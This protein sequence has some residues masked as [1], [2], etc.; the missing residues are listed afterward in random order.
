MT[1]LLEKTLSSPDW[2]LAVPSRGGDPRREAGMVSPPPS[3]PRRNRKEALEA[4]DPYATLPQLGA[5]PASGDPGVR[6]RPAH[7]LPGAGAN[8]VLETVVIQVLPEVD[9]L[10]AL[11][12]HERA[13]LPGEGPYGRV[14]VD[15]LP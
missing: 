15:L 8:L 1:L 12:K 9:A 6:A 5:A 4:L 10:G 3:P 14:G 7:D 2:S 13:P 11:A